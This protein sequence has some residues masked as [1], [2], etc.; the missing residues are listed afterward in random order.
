VGWLLEL[1]PPEYR[2][3]D[4]LTRHPIVLARFA[5]HHLDAA[6]SAA[7]TGFAGARTELADVLDAPQ[8]ESVLATYERE[9]RRL[10]AAARSVSLVRAALE[11]TRFRARL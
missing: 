9:G 11:G 10:V 7:R 8:I 5:A 2:A 3:Y 1:V 6:V 4:A